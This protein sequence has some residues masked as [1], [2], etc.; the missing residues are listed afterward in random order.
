MFAY[1]VEVLWGDGSL[2]KLAERDELGAAI[3]EAFRIAAAYQSSDVARQVAEIAVRK[4]GKLE[5]AIIDNPK[6]LNNVKCNNG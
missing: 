3:D 6:L 2:Q 1:I 5:I 4:D